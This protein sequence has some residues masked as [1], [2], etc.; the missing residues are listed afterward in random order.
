LEKE[1]ELLTC[2]QDSAAQKHLSLCCTPTFGMAYLPQV[3]SNFIRA[4]SDIND[5]KFIFLQPEE[6]LRGLRQEE[7]DLAAI[8]H[9]LDLNFPGFNRFSMPDDEM[10]VVTSAAAPIPNDDGVIQ[11]S[12]LKEKRLFA[13]R[14]G[15]SSKELMRC[16]LRAQGLDFNDFASVVI[17]D[18]LRFTIQ[19]V[20]AGE[21]VAYMSQALISS[22][23]ESEQM[24]GLHVEGFQRRRGRSV[25][26]LPQKGEDPLVKALLEIIFDVVS[27]FW[28]PKMVSTAD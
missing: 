4:H 17:S 18:D 19:S 1:K 24:I 22:Y 11:V 2:L 25:V 20:L 21:G 13:R 10:L 23:L 28:R 3:L 6:A 7:F 26:M 14:D 16:N 8:E 27:P 15:C 9:S 5:L 12:S